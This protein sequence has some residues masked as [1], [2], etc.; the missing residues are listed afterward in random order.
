MARKRLVVFAAVS[1]VLLIGGGVAAACVGVPG[2]QAASAT[3]DA[4]TVGDLSSN[5]CTAANGDTLVSTRGSYTGSASSSDAQLNGP[6]VIYARSLVDTTTGVGYVEG[7]FE[8]GPDG[9]ANDGHFV[10]ALS[11]G[12]A[13]GFAEAELQSPDGRLLASLSSTMTLPAAGFNCGSRVIAR[14]WMVWPGL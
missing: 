3:F 14:R 2:V 1:S 5:S 6:L 12:G 4:T 9:S 8:V 13:T 10:A 7:R 11:G